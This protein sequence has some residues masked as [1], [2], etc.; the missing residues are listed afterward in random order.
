MIKD[1][2]EISLRGHNYIDHRDVKRSLFEFKTIQILS[3]SVTEMRVTIPPAW[4]PSDLY[5]NG[6][7]IEGIAKPGCYLL[8]VDQELLNAAPCPAQ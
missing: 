4:V 3:R 6:L 5:W 8:S 7:S 2:S 1:F